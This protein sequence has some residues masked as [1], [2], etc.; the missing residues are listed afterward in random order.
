MTPESY[1]TTLA[2]IRVVPSPEGLYSSPTWFG[3]WIIV[4]YAAK[5]EKGLARI[6]IWRLRT[7]GSEF[8]RIELPNHASCGS[9]GLNGFLEPAVLP[10]GRLSYAVDCAP[11]GDPFG[12]RTHLMAYDAETREVVQLLNSSLPSEYVGTGGYAWDPQMTR[13]IMGDGHR[14][15]DE[16]LYWFTREIS[17]PIDVGLPLAYAPSWS[18]DGG[19]IAFIG[20]RSK[21]SPV[22]DR[23]VHGIYLINSD[24]TDVR[25]LLEGF[26]DSGGVS[27]SPDGRWLAFPG[28]FGQREGEEQGLWLVDVETGERRLV[29]E[30]LIGVPNWS[31]DGQRIVAVRL[32]GPP[33]DR[34]DE[35][36]IVEVGPVLGD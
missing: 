33:L 26:D 11:A 20:S 4:Q 25:L 19:R 13:M 34:E 12:A 14:Y 22:I 9:D 15:I 16:Q 8:E 3:D 29:A 32:K 7:D 1:T 36:V 31:P 18:P 28:R 2:N 27:F 10:D 21:G 35:L 5:L 23:T 30:G 6:G 17:E 24:G